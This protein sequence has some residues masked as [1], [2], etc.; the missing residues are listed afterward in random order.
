[1]CMLNDKSVNHHVE[2]LKV[3]TGFCYFLFLFRFH[4]HFSL[5][6]L[7]CFCSSFSRH[8]KSRPWGKNGRTPCPG[9]SP[10]P[11]RSLKLFSNNYFLWRGFWKMF[12][13]LCFFEKMPKQKD[14]KTNHAMDLFQRSSVA[15][16]AWHRDGRVRPDSARHEKH[17]KKFRKA[18][19]ATLKFPDLNSRH[20]PCARCLVRA[21]T[22]PASAQSLTRFG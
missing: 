5:S 18:A 1:M 16:A 11:W 8:Q 15:A 22:C 13:S 6:S 7:W 17:V 19:V 9:E 12:R 20:C 2:H 21:Q 10:W 4:S 14:F 3:L